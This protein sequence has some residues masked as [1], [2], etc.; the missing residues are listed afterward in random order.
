MQFEQQVH[1]YLEQKN[2]IDELLSSYKAMEDQL[3]VKEVK[4]SDL[5][6]LLK[7]N[8]EMNSSTMK[9]VD[10]KREI[11]SAEDEFLHS[12]HHDGAGSL[13]LMMA[14]DAFLPSSMD[15]ETLSS[16][17]HLGAHHGPDQSHHS[18][19]GKNLVHDP[20]NSDDAFAARRAASLRAAFGSRGATP[21]S[22]SN[23]NSRDT[24]IKGD[25]QN[26]DLIAKEEVQDTMENFGCRGLLELMRA[27]ITTENESI[28]WR[29]AR[30]VRDIVHQNETIRRECVDD[31][32]DEITL[33]V[34]SQLKH[35]AV[36]QAQCIR[37][38]VKLH[39]G[40]EK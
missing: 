38:L 34:M 28:L 25:N 11:S 33:L 27:N 12:R 26:P 35:S 13:A 40:V 37:L 36:V 22:F 5:E 3:K 24:E 21:A 23:Q 1:V 8:T 19:H 14:H 31:L 2:K 29:A 4:I 39:N 32:G 10:E 7:E 18:H 15:T 17:G 9:N 20:D 16:A 30:A 6:R